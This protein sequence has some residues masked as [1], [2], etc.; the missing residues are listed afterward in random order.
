MA[1]GTRA[2]VDPNRLYKALS[3]AEAPRQL[4][5]F[6]AAAWAFIEL[7]A[8][9]DYDTRIGLE[10]TLVLPNGT[11]AQYNAALVAAACR[12]VG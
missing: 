5:G 4:H 3:G 11:R 7:A 12:I 1:F 8:P 9:R 6:E 2:G 10:N